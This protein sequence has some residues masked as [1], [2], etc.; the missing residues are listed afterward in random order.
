M[1]KSVYKDTR[2]GCPTNG[3]MDEVTLVIGVTQTKS[4]KSATVYQCS[5]IGCVFQWQGRTENHV[6]P[7]AVRCLYLSSEIRIKIARSLS[8]KSPEARVLASAHAEETATSERGTSQGLLTSPMSQSTARAYFKG[9]GK[10]QLKD[11][12]DAAMVKMFC[13]NG[14]PPNFADSPEYKEYSN[15]LN[16]T[17]NPPGRTTLTEKFIPATQ[18]LIQQQQI[19]YLTTQ[20]NLTVTYDGGQTRRRHHFYTI[21][22]L[23]EDGRAFLMDMVDGRN[24]SRTGI[25]IKESVLRVS[26]SQILYTLSF[27]FTSGA[28]LLPYE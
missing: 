15:I 5:G 27:E 8:Q 18:A 13:V 26:L 21:H 14:L 20:R 22:I 7:H 16:P 10:A 4:G 6:L 23:T 25:W 1:K 11:K 24:V 9:A 3:L 28:L 2:K 12:A 19:D 17:Y